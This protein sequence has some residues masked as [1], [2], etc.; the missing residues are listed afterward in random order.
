[1]RRSSTGARRVADAYRSRLGTAIGRRTE[2]QKRGDSW[3][4]G[5]AVRESTSDL[6][7]CNGEAELRFSKLKSKFIEFFGHSPDIYV[8][9]PGRVNLIGEHIYYEGYSVLPMAIRQDTI[10]AIRK[11]K[12]QKAAIFNWGEAS[13]RRVPEPTRYGDWEKNGEAKEGRLL[14]FWAGGEREHQRFERLQRQ[15]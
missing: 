11:V 15:T 1:M 13:G 6:R 14:G 3:D 7:G 9:S 12:G 8:R 5:L 4:F 2:R 10:V